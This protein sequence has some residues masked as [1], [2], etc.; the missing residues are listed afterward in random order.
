MDE[1]KLRNRCEPG[2]SSNSIPTPH[3]HLPRHRLTALQRRQL[4]GNL[5]NACLA[6]GPRRGV[7]RDRD[8]GV[9]PK[10]VRWRQGLDAKHIQRGTG[11][12]TTVEQREQIVI[13]QMR[14]ARHV[15][16]VAAGL[17]AAQGIA[18]HDALGLD[19]ERQQVDQ[20]AAGRQK[21]IVLLRPPKSHGL[22][23]VFGRAASTLDR[24]QHTEI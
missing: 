10:R 23:P 12:V 9:P 4:T 2:I 13:D 16:D 11:Q 3:I 24:H 18:V 17:Q 20:N 5:R 1:S 8:L 22:R 21:C 6:Q 7:R 15:D 14:T 19:G